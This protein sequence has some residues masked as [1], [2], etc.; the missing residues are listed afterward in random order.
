MKKLTTPAFKTIRDCII[1]QA[2]INSDSLLL[3]DWMSVLSHAHWLGFNIKTEQAKLSQA[4]KDNN[5]QDFET[6]DIEDHRQL[7]A[8]CDRELKVET[9][10]STF[11]AD[12]NYLRSALG[13]KAIGK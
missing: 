5:C 12:L 10:L 4:L 2:R 1:P 13:V 8:I 11:D 7:L 6:R 9:Y 3:A